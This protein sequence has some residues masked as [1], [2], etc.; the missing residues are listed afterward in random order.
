MNT[1]S[2]DISSA[3]IPPELAVLVEG[4]TWSQIDT[5]CSAAHVYRLH[6]DNRPG[7]YLKS[8]SIAAGGHSLEPEHQRLEWLQGRLPVPKVLGFTQSDG[9][10]HLLLS[11]VT[12]TPAHTLSH[13]DSIESLVHLLAEGLRM[14]H[15]LPADD[16]PFRH[17]IDA[18]I[19]V[20]RERM[21]AGL[22][23]EDDFDEARQGRSAGEL[24]EELLNTIPSSEETVFSHGDYCMPNIIVDGDSISG[25]IDMGRAG[26]GDRYRDLALAVRSIQFNYGREWVEPFLQE[27]GIDSVDWKKMEFFQLLDEFF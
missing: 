24:F 22:V 15:A 21:M 20:A 16:C 4:Y 6:A 8:A 17:D 19:A 26:M 25:F 10:R 1:D 14:I 23:D 2:T 11:E 18:E 3:S 7:L 12:G 13:T 27:Y 5:G 9:F